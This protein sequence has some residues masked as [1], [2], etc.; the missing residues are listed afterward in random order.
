MVLASH[1]EVKRHSVAKFVSIQLSIF[2]PQWGGKL[3][4]SPFFQRFEGHVEQSVKI[5]VHWNGFEQRN[6]ADELE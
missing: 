2:P 6:T 3:P 1:P 4:P 5:L